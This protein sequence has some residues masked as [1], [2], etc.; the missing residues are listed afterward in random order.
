MTSRILYVEQ[1]KQAD[2]LLHAFCTT[3]ETLYGEQYVTPNMHMHGHL[4]S[5]LLD[6]GPVYSFWLFSYERYNGILGTFPTKQKSIE[7]Q[8]MRRFLRDNVITS[9]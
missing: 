5:S 1:I 2:Q 8:L 7:V 4:I 9:M 3:F 6:Y